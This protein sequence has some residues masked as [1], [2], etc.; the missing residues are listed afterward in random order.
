MAANFTAEG[1]I[2]AVAF[3]VGAAAASNLTSGASNQ[4]TWNNEIY[5]TG[6][7]FASNV[8]TAP[9]AGKYLICLSFYNTSVD[10]DAAYMET[11]MVTSN[12]S[13]SFIFDPG[14]LATDPVYWGTAHSHVCQMDAGDTAT[15][16]VVPGSGASQQDLGGDSWISGALLS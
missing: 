3:M 15:G 6:A 4:I 1:P 8:F 14:P 11:V 2:G 10:R 12:R 9:V 13:I 5:D 7:N 16:K